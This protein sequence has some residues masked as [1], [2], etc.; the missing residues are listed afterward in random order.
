MRTLMDEPVSDAAEDRMIDAAVERAFAEDRFDTAEPVPVAPSLSVI[1]DNVYLAYVSV[2]MPRLNF[3]VRGAA[4]EVNG[5]A[6]NKSQA[7]EPQ[8]KLLPDEH[9][10]ALQRFELE[11]TRICTRYNIPVRTRSSVAGETTQTPYELAEQVAAAADN[12]ARPRPTEHTFYLKGCYLIPESRLDD[13][14]EE[15]DQLNTNLR[16][17][18]RTEIAADMERFR[19]SVRM[20]LN[21]DEAYE[22]ARR[23]IPNAEEL[24]SKTCIDWTPI[25]ISL[26]SNRD[27][28]DTNMSELR[29]KA[30]ERRLTDLFV[31]WNLGS[32]RETWSSYD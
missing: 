7:T 3:K 28:R 20:Q 24:L 2:H 12:D 17:Y 5:V 31:I 8:W 22:E 14:V 1:N 29:R 26:G 30:I 4:V 21:D 23:H 27:A 32:P 15:M 11:K 16:D 13:F 6:L 19:H 18:V 10:K 9:K 25:P